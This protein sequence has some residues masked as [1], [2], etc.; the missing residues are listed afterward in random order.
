MLNPPGSPKQIGAYTFPDKIWGINAVGRL[1]YAAVDKFGLGILDLA[2]PAAPSLAGS[3]KTPGQAKSV[4]LVAKTALVADHMSGV[5]FI[6]VSDVGKP[7]LLGSFYLE[8]YARA[9]AAFGSLAAAVD[10]PTG[11]YVFDLTKPRT[12]EPIATVQSA[13]RPGT[14]DVD[15]AGASGTNLAVL[16]GAGSV[17]VYDLSNPAAPAK[18]ATITTPGGRPQRAVIR[19]RTAFVADAALGVQVIDLATPSAPRVVTTFKTPAPVREVAVTD[20]LVLA[21]IGQGS[22]SEAASP[23]EGSVL[24]LRR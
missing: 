13:E 22:S 2:N 4:A 5:D 16:V 3:I 21:A 9:V 11:L 24:I 8:G 15:P 18:A 7:A 1:V 23:P 10:S 6:D 14:I 12:L 19:G 20:S 17:Q